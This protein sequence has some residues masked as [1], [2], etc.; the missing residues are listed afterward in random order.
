VN[1]PKV[2]FEFLLRAFASTLVNPSSPLW[3][4]FL[5][6]YSINARDPRTNN[7]LLMHFV[8]CTNENAVAAITQCGELDVGAKDSH[9][10]TALHHMMRMLPDRPVPAR[11]TQIVGSLLVVA[12]FP[13]FLTNK[14]GQSAVDIFLQRGGVIRKKEDQPREKAAMEAILEYVDYYKQS[15]LVLH[16]KSFSLAA[17]I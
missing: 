12:N 16:N 15:E 1:D 5:K 3:E 13:L 8:L 17:L 6:T 4:T 9:G 10:D 14:M 7:T 2:Q 11:Y